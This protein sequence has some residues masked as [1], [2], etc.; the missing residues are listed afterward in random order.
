M[1]TT[2]NIL[3]DLSLLGL[4]EVENEKQI[5]YSWKKTL[6]K[7]HQDIGGD[8]LTS[9]RVIEAYEKLMNYDHTHEQKFLEYFN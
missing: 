5:K 8:T 9:Q 2:K 7:V 1:Y 4:K 6:K 3:D